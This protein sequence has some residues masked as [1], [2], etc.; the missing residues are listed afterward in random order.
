[1]GPNRPKNDHDI[2]TER[3]NRLIDGKNACAAKTDALRLV[4]PGSKKGLLFQPLDIIIRMS[5]DH[6]WI[7]DVPDFYGAVNRL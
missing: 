5:F 3:R 7:E 6:V 4:R 1:M 2:S